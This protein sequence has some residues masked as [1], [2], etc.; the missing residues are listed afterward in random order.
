VIPVAFYVVEK[1]MA[2]FG[3]RRTEHRKQEINGREPGMQQGPA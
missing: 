2:R 3:K 1:I